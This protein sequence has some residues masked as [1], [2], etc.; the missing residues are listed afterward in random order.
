[1][2]LEQYTYLAEIIGMIIVVVTLLYLSAQVRQGAHLMRSE[3][4]QALLNNDR[5][6]L[7][8]YLDNMDLFEKLADQQ[9]LSR[10]DQRRFSVLWII[11]MR[12]REHEWFQYKDGILDEATWQSYREIMRLTLASNRHRTWWNKAKI[13]FDPDFVELVDLFIGEIPESDSWEE[14]MGAWDRA[15]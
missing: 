10:S 12:N 4:R 5:A 7:L 6:S 13:A 11:N 9:E 14:F 15:A 1:M 2:S 8:P 3:S